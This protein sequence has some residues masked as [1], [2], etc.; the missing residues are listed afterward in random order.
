MTDKD[1][2]DLRKAYI[3]ATRNL[4]E[5]Q[6]ASKKFMAVELEPDDD[7]KDIGFSHE[8]V[9]KAFEKRRKA[10][11][12]YYEALEAWMQCVSNE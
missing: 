4:E 9:K 3:E 2:D 5:C 8:E 1:C 10:E 7:L 11:D 12:E 6:N